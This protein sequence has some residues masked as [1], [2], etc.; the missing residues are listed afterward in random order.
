MTVEKRG[1]KRSD[2]A[3]LKAVRN[4]IYRHMQSQV[5]IVVELILKDASADFMGQELSNG[6]KRSSKATTKC[7]RTAYYAAKENRP[8]TDYESLI[9]LQET[10]EVDIGT[11][12]HGRTTCMS[13]IKVISDSMKTDVCADIALNKSKISPIVDESTSVSKKSRLILYLRAQLD[14]AELPQNVFL[15]LVELSDQVAEVICNTILKILENNGINNAF[16]QRNLIAFC[17]DGASVMLGKCSGVGTRLKSKCPNLILWH[18]L[19]HRLELAVGDSVKAVD[20]FYHIQ[21][22]FDKIYFCYSYFAKF[23]RELQ[24]IATEL[25]IEIKKIGK[26]FIIMQLFM[27]I[28]S[29]CQR[30]SFVD[31]TTKL[32][33]RV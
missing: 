11:T 4:K 5:H 33:T 6:R 14:N 22:L 28:S 30:A 32:C 24:K 10:N 9:A 26:L 15:Q 27:N 19:N 13:M 25:E 31:R 20:G 29:D 18:C 16:L 12:L 2:G 21:T 8:I 1:Q 3:T 17:S 7:L 23:Q